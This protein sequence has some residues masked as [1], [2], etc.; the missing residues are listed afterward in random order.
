MMDSMGSLIK[1]SK[2]KILSVA[3]TSIKPTVLFKE[4]VP[5]PPPSFT[6]MPVKDDPIDDGG[7]TVDG[8]DKT[9]DDKTVD[10]KTVDDKTVDD[11]TV[12]DKT[13]DVPIKRGRGRPR[14]SKNKKQEK[15]SF[16]DDKTT[17][18]KEKW[19]TELKCHWRYV[20]TEEFNQHVQHWLSE[21]ETKL[22]NS[23]SNV[24]LK[25]KVENA[26]LLASNRWTLR[27][28]VEVMLEGGTTG[29]GQINGFFVVDP[30]SDNDPCVDPLEPLM[31]IE[32]LW[33]YSR[34]STSEYCG[35]TVV[36]E[37]HEY[38]RCTDDL[39]LI[40]MNMI[41][42]LHPPIT[43][44]YRFKL[45]GPQRCILQRLVTTAVAAGSTPVPAAAS[46]IGETV[47]PGVGKLTKRKKLP[48]GYVLVDD[49]T[50]TIV[51]PSSN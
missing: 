22:A 34:Y 44:S 35:T 28:R 30:H 3:N 16:D 19:S 4:A 45:T 37:P 40:S 23:P 13:V 38:A 1:T 14:G 5:P 9:V 21:Q 15:T 25:T 31:Q 46:A 41:A 20:K 8:D 50:N 6:S 51:D 17:E 26:R 39:S 27:T 18:G 7:K 48:K 11:K 12:D 49:L 29:Y 42:T 24:D 33:P 36:A 43:V 10:D 2:L 32:Y 47:K